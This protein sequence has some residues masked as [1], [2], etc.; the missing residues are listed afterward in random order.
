M[1]RVAVCGRAGPAPTRIRQ[2]GP[3]GGA[4]PLRFDVVIGSCTVART[5]LPYSSGCW[6]GLYARILADDYNPLHGDNSGNTAY[7]R[8]VAAVDEALVGAHPSGTPGKESAYCVSSPCTAFHFD[9]GTSF[10]NV[11]RGVSAR[12]A[13]TAACAACS[14]TCTASVN[15]RSTSAAACIIGATARAASTTAWAARGPL[16]GAA[17]R[18]R[19]LPR[20]AAAGAISA[21]TRAAC[22][23]A[24]I[25]A[26]HA[27][28]LLCSAA[29]CR[30][31]L[32]SAL[33]C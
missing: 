26:V 23:R 22:T 33:C 8:D 16:H 19:R 17:H 9:A 5:K 11:R 21:T 12:T 13:G 27:S 2:C 10:G 14:S 32:P 28:G 1:A 25:I 6:P 7:L 18:R 29:H 24:V 31:L 15:A 30:D 4:P 20:S 3:N